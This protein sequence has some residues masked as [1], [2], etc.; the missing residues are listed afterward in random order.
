[1]ASLQFVCNIKSVLLLL[2]LVNE[3]LNIEPVCVLLEKWMVT[4]CLKGQWTPQSRLPYWEYPAYVMSPLER[5]KP[6]VRVT[7]TH[8][9][10]D[11]ISDCQQVWFVLTPG[12]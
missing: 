8:T 7:L 11:L 12:R 6:L 3:A 1:M 10:L 5:G 4:M 9:L 2:L